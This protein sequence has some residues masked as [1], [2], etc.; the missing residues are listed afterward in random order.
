MWHQLGLEIVHRSST[1]TS[2]VGTGVLN[3]KFTQK[4]PQFCSVIFL[5]SHSP[6]RFWYYDFQVLNTVG[7]S[8][9]KI[10]KKSWS[11]KGSLAPNPVRSSVLVY[12]YIL[13]STSFSRNEERRLGIF[14]PVA[15]KQSNVMCLTTEHCT[16]SEWYYQDI[17]TIDHT[18]YCL[19]LDEYNEFLICSSYK[20][21][22]WK[23]NL[24][25]FL[26]KSHYSQIQMLWR[27][28]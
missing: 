10:N 12:T 26:S 21:S 14:S 23:D 18:A 17:A 13:L 1:F 7:T 27:T 28:G 22:W 24:P 4:A 19:S 8:D 2:Q 6:Q 9:V 15:W 11:R 16:I 5:A 3:L 25:W 20:D